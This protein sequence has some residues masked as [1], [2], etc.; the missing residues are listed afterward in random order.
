MPFHSE[1]APPRAR[2]RPLVLVVVSLAML[3]PLAL[4][5]LF[6]LSSPLEDYLVLHITMEGFSVIVASLIFTIAWHT[7]GPSRSPA[8][9]LLGAGFLAVALLDGLHL[10]SYAGMPRLVTEGGAAKAIWFWLAARATAAVAL[11]VF[12]LS[13][14]GP[15]VRAWTLAA[16]VGWAALVTWAVLFHLEALPAVFVPGVG[17]TGF[18][19]GLEFAI[20]GLNLTT[21]TVLLVRRPPALAS[22]LELLAAAAL[23]MA[24]SE[25]PLC[26]Y[27]TLSDAFNLLG[28]LEK[29]VAYSLLYR[30]LFLETVRE[31]YLQLEEQRDALALSE[32]RFRELANTV[33]DVFFVRDAKTR[34]LLYISPAFELI[35]GRPVADIMGGPELMVPF[36]HP[37]DREHVA[38]EQQAQLERETS[39]EYRVLRP[40]GEARW[41]NART[42]PVRDEKGEVIRIAGV[43]RDVTE[44]KALLANLVTSQKMESVARLSAG[45]AHDFNNLLTII[46]SSAEFAAQ[47]AK[48]KP[49]LEEDIAQIDAAAHRAQDLTRQLLSFA[50]KDVAQPRVIDAVAAVT[51]LGPILQRLAGRD[52]KVETAHAPGRLPVKIDK[53]QLEQLVMNFVGNARDAMPHGG[54]V[55]VEV[56]DATDAEVEQHPRADRRRAWV[57]LSVTDEGVG[58]TDEAKQRAFEPFFTTKPVG[59]GTGLGL[60]TCAAIVTQALGTIRLESALGQGTRLEV[61]LPRVEPGAV[62]ELPRPARR[63]RGE[64]VLVVDDDVQVRRSAARVLTTH[65]YAVKEASNGLEALAVARATEALALVV[66]DLHMPGLDGAGLASELQRVLPK[67][68]VLFTSAFASD[69][70]LPGPLLPKPYLASD[71]ARA[72][73]E[74][75]DHTDVGAA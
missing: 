59:R 71:L 33:H 1:V 40:D 68:R 14:P 19:V 22:R 11:L 60:S 6:P 25:L 44:E 9:A 13:K 72:V 4:A 3:V 67:L 10:L 20:V 35:W 36:T 5:V 29:V 75:L 50:R 24:L 70:K 69:T 26:L 52:V 45:L 34:K 55:R 28:H 57:L 46:L 53:S 51:A 15:P 54:V 41:V 18:K 8:A 73:A 39:F 38:R 21:M 49:E 12:A 66:T 58:M 48:G 47:A 56:R 61:L 7:A 64:V 74:L 31:P 63:G 37:D 62:V 65:G 17:L 23:A 30:A 27:V 16:A 43:T 32:A 42:R 2:V